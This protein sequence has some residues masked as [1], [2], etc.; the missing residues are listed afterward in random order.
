MNR[1]PNRV[2]AVSTASS[3]AAPRSCFLSHDASACPQTKRG[4]KNS[5]L[6]FPVLMP[7]IQTV[8]AKFVDV[9]NGTIAIT[10][11]CELGSLGN[12]RVP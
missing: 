2:S 6:G 9:D 8:V 1:L 3:K 7:R 4:G 10:T 12:S 11:Q 5:R